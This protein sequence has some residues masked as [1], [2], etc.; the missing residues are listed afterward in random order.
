MTPQTNHASDS[1]PQLK[2]TNALEGDHIKIIGQ[3]LGKER[4][5]ETIT[6]E[7]DNNKCN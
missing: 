7:V 2:L 4:R 5:K 1:Q 6:S 3:V